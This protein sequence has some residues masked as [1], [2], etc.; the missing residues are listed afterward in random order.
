[1][2]TIQYITA[3]ILTL[4]LFS[5]ETVLDVELPE[6]ET[7]LVAHCFVMNTDDQLSTYVSTNVALLSNQ[8]PA[9]ID[10]AT[11]QIFENGGLKYEFL[12]DQSVDLAE[13]FQ[14]GRTY[15]IRVSHPDL[16]SLSARQVMP[17][18]V[19]ITRAE[20]DPD[21][22]INE[23]GDEVA[24][25]VVTLLDPAG[26]ENY[27]ERG[28]VRVQ[29]GSGGEAY[30]LYPTDDQLFGKAT[31]NDFITFDDRTFDGRE[32]TLTF[33][34]YADYGGMNENYYLVWRSVSRERY[35]YLNSLTDQ[36]WNEDNPFSEPVPVFSNMEGGLGIFGLG[37]EEVL[38]VEVR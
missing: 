17:G 30:R 35:L 32:Q 24:E 15:E 22:G 1:M 33:R 36:L 25:L 23:F 14:T 13:P 4:F 5:C 3:L 9:G 28:L 34:F 8:E 38:A 16:G 7:R 2:R 37:W 29:G 10:N 31:W 26:E 19:A 20:L 27:Y 18:P 12:S 6:P 11:V 21:G